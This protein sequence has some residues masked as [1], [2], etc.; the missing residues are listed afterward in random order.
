MP[1]PM[2]MPRFPNTAL[3]TKPVNKQSSWKRN[4]ITQIFGTL[5]T[6]KTANKEHSR[7]VDNLVSFAVDGVFY[8]ISI[9]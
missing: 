1:M 6:S 9:N 3:H 8:T 5:L 2:P 4:K 7:Y